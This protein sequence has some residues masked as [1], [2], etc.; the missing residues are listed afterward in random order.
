MLPAVWNYVIHKILNMSATTS[1]VNTS[2]SF[3]QMSDV[4]LCNDLSCKSLVAL[5]SA[6]GQGTNTCLM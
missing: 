5:G 3:G 6:Y 2:L 1:I 4:G